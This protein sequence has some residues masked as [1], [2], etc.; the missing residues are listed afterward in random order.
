MMQLA[1]VKCVLVLMI[2][3]HFGGVQI[4]RYCNSF[5]DPVGQAGT[6]GLVE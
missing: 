3:S 2:L 6:G 5:E 4:S 1:R